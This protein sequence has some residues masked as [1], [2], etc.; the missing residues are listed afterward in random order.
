MKRTKIVCTIG[1]AS[2]D[3]KT[4]EKMITNGMNVARLNFSHG[5]YAE[6]Q[7]LIDNIRAASEKL[8][9]P[10]AILQDLQGPKIRVGALEKPVKI[11]KGQTIVIGEAFDMDF[12]I[13]SSV[14]PGERILI[15]DGIMELVVTKVTKARAGSKAHGK[16]ACKIMT[17]GEVRSHKGINLPDSKI[18]FPIYTK[19]D[20]ED[21]KFGLKADVDY[22][23]L[24]FVRDAS[25]IRHIKKL[26][27]K[28]LP[29]GKIAPKVIAK[30]E[31][32]EAVANIDAILLETDCI[33]VARGD[34]GVEIADSQV[35]LIQKSLIQKCNALA[36]PVIV[37]T[38]MLDSMIRNPRP[39]RA[40]VSDVANAV[41][42]R[43]DAVMLSGES[44][45]G[46]YAVEAVAEMTRIIEATEASPYD[47]LPSGEY[48][49]NVTDDYKASL[50]AGAVLRLAVGQ[51]A[52][53]IIGTTESGY[54]A[55]FISRERPNNP[56]LIL[57]DEQ[58]VRR[59]MALMWGVIP[60]YVDSLKA[61]KNVDALLKVFVDKARRRK[62]VKNGDK[63]VLVAGSPLGQRMNLIQT[64]TVK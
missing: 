6:H 64:V 22:V 10:I 23:A 35:P 54:T 1:P 55:R 2:K 13:S 14:K 56:I 34:L 26:V 36:K 63:V 20:I 51:D 27:E 48:K 15:E 60:L 46:Q 32:A 24:S 7:S 59:Q 58:K 25:D 5:S 41:I 43:A 8:K 40:E 30:I 45:F 18:N 44:A 9:K 53:A 52:S 39:T 16:I 47:D 49:G 29:K 12:D 21:L 61:L 31:R 42:E 3:Q 19:K 62:L 38:Q 17:S 50:I 37:A 4:L 33:M 11:T 57:T 28:Y